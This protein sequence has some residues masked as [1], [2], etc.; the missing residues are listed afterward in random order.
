VRFRD[1]APFSIVQVMDI[2][3]SGQIGRDAG[4]ALNL[5]PAGLPITNRNFASLDHADG[6]IL[7]HLDLLMK[8]RGPEIAEALLVDALRRKLHLYSLDPLDQFPALSREAENCGLVWRSPKLDLHPALIAEAVTAQDLPVDVPVLGVF[9]TRSRQGK[10][11][12]QMELRRQLEHEGYRI[13]HLATEPQA[14]LLRGDALFPMGYGT[15]ITLDLRYWIPYIRLQ[16]L[17]ICQHQRPD[18]V[19]VGSQSGSFPRDPHLR[20]RFLCLNS[21]HF[22]YGARP[23]AVILCVE[24][25]PDA[26]EAEYTK[27]TISAI[28]FL[29]KARVIALSFSGLLSA[30]GPSARLRTSR[31]MDEEESFIAARR[32]SELYGLPT[33]CPT[34]PGQR[35]AL[36]DEVIRFFA[37]KSP[38][39]CTA[40]D[41]LS[42]R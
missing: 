34:V 36:C 42:G 11:T 23:D 41:P 9:G 25:E 16:L 1:L 5:A 7:G 30:R 35:A 27:Q 10:F 19:I 38:D 29:G 17:A 14:K 40:A 15:P 31:F 32:L 6:L 28:R 26:A 12:T 21:L 13:G 8:L 24:Q 39:A 20:S 18:M 2:L 37:E 3:G 22:L 33:F 4:E